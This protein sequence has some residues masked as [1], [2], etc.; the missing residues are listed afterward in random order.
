MR[1]LVHRSVARLIVPVL[2]SLLALTMTAAADASPVAISLVPTSTSLTVPASPLALFA[3]IEL[4][5]AVSPDPG[6]G[7]VNFFVDDLNRASGEIGAGGIAS[8]TLPFLL[9]PGTN[10]FF[11]RFF[12]NST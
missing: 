9:G 11:A 1:G 12:G 6:G 8:A 4:S 7:W 5:A 3:P 10:S 2:V